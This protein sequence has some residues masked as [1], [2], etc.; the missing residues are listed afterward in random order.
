MK[1]LSVKE[2]WASLIMRWLKTIET[3]TWNVKYRGPVLICC[4]KTPKT[5][6]SGLALCVVDIVGCK[7]M[8]EIDQIR[9]CCPVYPNAKSWLLANVRKIKPF[10]VKGKLSLFETDE[11]LIHY[12]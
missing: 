5:E 10:P 3:R 1:S 4:A 8:D 2:P 9:A 6:Y 12:E 7:V 11:R